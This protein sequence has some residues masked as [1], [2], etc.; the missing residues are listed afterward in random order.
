[1]MSE[2]D[3]APLSTACVRALN[4]KL[5]DKRKAAAVEIEKMVKEF[6]S[7]NNT[8]QIKR[9][10]KVLGQDF[11]NS[12]NAHTRK[13][14]LI[15]LAAIAVAL[16]KQDCGLYTKELVYPILA[17]FTDSDLRVR[18][19]ACESL[20]NVVKVARGS[21][22]IHFSDIFSALSKL[23]ADPDQNVK[24][25]AELL[26][27]LMK[28]IVTESASFDLV[29][30]VPVLR[31]MMYT[32]N[33]FTRQFVISWVSALYAVPDIDLIPFLP[34]I[35]DG[36]FRILEDPTQEIKKMCDTALG[37]FLRSIK[38]DPSRVD[39]AAMINIL[40]THAQATDEVL[41]F[42]AIT[43]IKEFV[44]LS[45][46]M[47]LPFASG[48]L[49]STLPCLSYDS[50]SRRNIKETSKAVNFSLMKLISESV[51]AEVTNE[52]HKHSASGTG[53]DSEDQPENHRSDLDLP[54]V[55]DVLKKHL[56]HTCV[57][58]KVAALRWLGFLHSVIPSKMY[59]H[60][61]ELFPDL[62]RTLSDASDEVVKQDLE[63][64]A[65]VI[66]LSRSEKTGESGNV[67]KNSSDTTHLH[68]PYF[69]KFLVNLLKLFN[70]DRHLLEDRGP[71]IIRQL[72]VSLNS[73]DVYRTL[74]EIIQHEDNLKFAAIMVENLNT[75]LLT[76]PELFELRTKL[77]DVKSEG[78]CQ[79][80]R[81][82]Y[83][84]WCHNP[85]ATV[86]LCLLTQ[87]YSHAC[88][89]IHKFGSLEVT[90]EFLTEIDK[91][92]QLIESPIFTYL[93]LELLEV[94]P[95]QHL[96]QALYGLLMLLPQ[97]EAFHTLRRR[98]DCIPSLHIQCS[99]RALHA[100]KEES[101]KHEKF[102]D[103]KQLLDHFIKIQDQHKRSKQAA[104][105]AA[106]LEKKITGLDT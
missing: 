87:N 13:G 6:A 81:C 39:F 10:L 89:L 52:E 56:V 22:L 98:L 34:E 32:K 61:D 31:D 53:G 28:D 40:I 71:F 78:S 70:G 16:G 51:S 104:R 82:L 65:G 44:Q 106:L 73:E 3:Y 17:C 24:N 93:R 58:T 5:Y 57:P 48:I 79:L 30:F 43:W 76:S 83:E 99:D 25:G 63:V 11:A 55:L 92:V 4:D 7:L 86:A 33:T 85:V 95:K 68:K 75:I 47:M 80:F 21:V 46:R 35:L 36:L 64:L 74:S 41:Q 42:T 102:L 67:P 1:M 60:V 72:C 29:A 20:Y 97:T 19:Y 84:S 77:K 9:L 100:T 94:P 66:S 49:T 90:V 88:D 62:L 37:E 101:N 12:Q 38:H 103:F 15:G 2:R 59:G 69:S 27:R 14:G 105:N 54:S 8:T 45:G 50:D 96:V 18:Y 23:A 91:L 26:D